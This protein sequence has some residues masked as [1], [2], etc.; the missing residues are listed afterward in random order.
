M[1]SRP[2]PTFLRKDA[3]PLRRKA[4]GCARSAADGVDVRTAVTVGTVRRE[5]IPVPVTTVD[6][7]ED[8]DVDSVAPFVAVVLVFVLAAIW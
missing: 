5:P 7:E 8:T 1:T 2:V 3:P 4:A 6:A